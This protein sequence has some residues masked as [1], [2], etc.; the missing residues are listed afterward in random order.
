MRI[1][2]KIQN[3][4]LKYIFKYRVR[5]V[6]N[7]TSPPSII[8]SNCI[9]G[10][11]YQVADLQYFSPTVGLWF[12]P[13]DFYKFVLNIGNYL[14][15]DLEF[16]YYTK[17]N[18]PVGLLGDIKIH[19]MHYDNFDDAI[20]S[21]TRRAARVNLN[22]IVVLNTDRDGCTR[23]KL[24]RLHKNS[25]YR[26]ISFVSK[27]GKEDFLDIVKIKAYENE[28]SVGDLYSDYQHLAFSFP[29]EVLKNE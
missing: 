16:G 11:V 19:F 28:S 6:I 26:V 13:D 23:D 25:P 12:E 24:L 18:Y 10:R 20:K 1:I 15:F 5:K 2:R 3:K 22:H 14:S 29:Y 17:D 21:W 7:H 27:G 9:G 8:S 4:A